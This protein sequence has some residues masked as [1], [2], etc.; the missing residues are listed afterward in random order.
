MKEVSMIRQS[1]Q[2]AAGN[3]PLTVHEYLEW[4]TWQV[5]RLLIILRN[6][7]DG[8]TRIQE[9]K[10][11]FSALRVTTSYSGVDFP[12]TAMSYLVQALNEAGVEV[13]HPQ[14]YS[15][16]DIGSAQQKVLCS[17]NGPGAPAHV[18]CDLN[19]RLPPTVRYRVDVLEPSERDN[20]QAKCAGYGKIGE[21]VESYFQGEQFD[22]HTKAPCVKCGTNCP[23][24]MK[25]D[26]EGIDIHIAGWTCTDWTVFGVPSLV[27]FHSESLSHGPVD[28]RS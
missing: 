24:Y 28:W 3:G 14:V 8:D 12:G 1:N 22:A 10:D 25:K 21:I 9:L 15:A 6:E 11:M 2:L 7:S 17:I 27:F 16:C 20:S 23:I 19:D 4:P 26:P 5:E 18:F 13:A